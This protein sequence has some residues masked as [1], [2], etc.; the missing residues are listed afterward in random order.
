[1]PAI[2]L[3]TSEKSIFTNQS[4]DTSNKTTDVASYIILILLMHIIYIIFIILIDNFILS[5]QS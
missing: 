2:I 4:T 1:M 5:S 3:I